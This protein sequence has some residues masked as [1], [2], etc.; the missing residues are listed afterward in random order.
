[1]KIL[2]FMVICFTGLTSTPS[3]AQNQSDDLKRIAMMIAQ[4]KSKP[5]ILKEWEAF[6]TQNPKIDVAKS[7][8]IIINLARQENKKIAEKK[9]KSL[10][11]NKSSMSSNKSFESIITDLQK[12]MHEAAKK[13]IANMKA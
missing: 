9:D 10:Q 6:V 13:V 4:G 2:L 5:E 11:E 7:I 8:N 3:A 12:K 1:M